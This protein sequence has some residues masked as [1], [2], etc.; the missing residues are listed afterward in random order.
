MT[1]GTSVVWE[2]RQHV[3]CRFSCDDRITDRT[4]TH[5]QASAIVIFCLSAAGLPVNYTRAQVA[6]KAA[7]ERH[8]GCSRIVV[9]HK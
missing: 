3:R 5:L 1:V 9:E 6:V 8:F 7:P 4:L 2:V